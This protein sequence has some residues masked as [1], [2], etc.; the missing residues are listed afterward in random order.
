MGTGPEFDAAGETRRRRLFVY[1]GGFLTQTRVRRIL[2]LAGYDVRVGLP[3]PD[4]AVGVWGMSPTSHR[5]EAVADRKDAPVIRVEEL[6]SGTM[7]AEGFTDQI[8]QMHRQLTAAGKSLVFTRRTMEGLASLTP[9][10]YAHFASKYELRP[11][12]HG[13]FSGYVL[14]DRG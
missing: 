2:D 1:N 12:E 4:D 8:D 6:W 5:G 7:S 9:T 10:L 3:G 13:T 11:I 14:V